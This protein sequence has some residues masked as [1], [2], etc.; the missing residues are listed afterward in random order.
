MR[1]CGLRVCLGR[2]GRCARGCA[3]TMCVLGV[4]CTHMHGSACMHACK[5]R[6]CTLACTRIHARM[7]STHVRANHRGLACTCAWTHAR[8]AMRTCMRDSQP[9]TPN[10]GAHV[11]VT[12]THRV[13]EVRVHQLLA[14]CGAAS[15]RPGL[16]PQPAH[17]VLIVQG[18]DL[19][20]IHLF[21]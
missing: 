20:G 6:A 8:A 7:E 14:H 21:L 17:L 1:W 9:R 15:C 5:V 16:K 18:E 10:R 12:G 19:Q 2:V 13:E 4:W 3:H 11:E